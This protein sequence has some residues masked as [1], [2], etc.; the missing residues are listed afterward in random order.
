MKKCREDMVEGTEATGEHRKYEKAA[1]GASQSAREE[2]E[3]TL[4]AH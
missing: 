4:S 3:L 1:A 2:R